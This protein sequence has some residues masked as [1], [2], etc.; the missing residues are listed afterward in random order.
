MICVQLNLP[1]QVDTWSTH[2]VY[3]KQVPS[4][5]ERFD[6]RNVLGLKVKYVTWQ[7]PA[8]DI[9]STVDNK[10]HL[11]DVIVVLEESY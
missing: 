2:I 6:F 7:V 8:R 1:Y 4:A 10:E 11:I 9:F 5:G 3:M